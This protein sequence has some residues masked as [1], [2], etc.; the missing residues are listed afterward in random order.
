MW[1]GTGTALGV[2][3]EQRYITTESFGQGQSKNIQLH[4]EERIKNKYL[5]SHNTE[6]RTRIRKKLKVNSSTPEG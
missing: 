2:V 1:I 6:N 3:V 4:E 5:F